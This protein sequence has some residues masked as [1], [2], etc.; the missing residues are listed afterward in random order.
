[1]ADPLLEIE[2]L[3]AGYG[4]RPVLHGIDLSVGP[5]EVVAL[6]GPN[7]AGKSTTLLAISGLIPTLSGTVRI[8]GAPRPRRPHR[9]AIEGLAHVPED[10]SLFP[11]LTVAEHLRLGA[12]SGGRSREEVLGWF[13]PLRRLIDRQVGLLSG[14]EQQMVALARALMSGPRLLLIDE[15]SLGLAPIVVESLLTTLGDIVEETGCG[16]LLVEQHVA[17][18][19][20][21]AQRA[22]VLSRGRV[23]VEGSAAAL[24]ADPDLLERAYLGGMTES[25][26]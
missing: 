23:V 14:G 10:R 1:M 3:R 2:G 18:A 12:R 26:A 21:V 5:S 17:M 19:L 20:T 6:L 4:G 9:A 25:P 15:M 16:V 22:V 24:R 13:A 11:S 8:H 7:G